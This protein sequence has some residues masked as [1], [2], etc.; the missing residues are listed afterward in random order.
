M[1]H[2]VEESREASWITLESKSGLKVT[3]CTV[4]AGVYAIEYKGKRLTLVL[5]DRERFIDSNQFF[6][7][8]LARVAGRLPLEYHFHDLVL[9]LP[10]NEPA[11]CLHAGR[12]ESLSY[13]NWDYEVKE[14]EGEAT[15]T[16]TYHSPDGECGFPGNV[17]A[18][19]SYTLRDDAPTFRLGF[20]AESDRLTP[21]S[22]SNH[23]YWDL[24][25]DNDVSGETLYMNADRMG[26]DDGK[27]QLIT[28]VKP[29]LPCLDFRTPHTLKASMDEV[30]ENL[31]TRNIDHTFLFTEV[32]SEKPQASLENDQIKIDLLTDMDAMN[33]Y[34]DN[35]CTP[36]KFDNG[37]EMAHKRRAIALEPQMFLLNIDELTLTP[38]KPIDHWIEYR[39][40]EK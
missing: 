3:T 30:E 9:N 26:D 33:I 5:S 17:V 11:D 19:V 29:I 4:G 31:V 7:K 13:R 14:G 6:G 37:T 34:V 1:K 21:F 10:Q 22:F 36:V 40:I 15:V 28:G 24:C 16:F 12:M 27:S 18:Q 32:D 20:H 38:E 25:D 23:I 39:V 2:T 8:T 35:S